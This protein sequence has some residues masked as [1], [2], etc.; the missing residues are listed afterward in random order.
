MMS[1]PDGITWTMVTHPSVDSVLTLSHGNGVWAA[2]AMSGGFLVRGVLT[3]P[4]GVTWT[5]QT[6]AGAPGGTFKASLF[7][8]GYHFTSLNLGSSNAVWRSTDGVTWT[9][10]P[11]S[12]RT[13]ANALAAGNGILV[14]LGFGSEGRCCVRSVA[15]GT[16]PAAPVVFLHNVS[17][18]S[19][20]RFYL[21]PAACSRIVLTSMSGSFGIS[22]PP[23][24]AEGQ[25][26]TI[27]ASATTVSTLYTATRDGS[28]IS[29]AA[30]SLASNASAAWAFSATG[31]RWDRIQ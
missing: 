9:A 3:S 24:P 23:S 26:F 13:P 17:T 31:N 11:V 19:S 16:K 6:I 1:S 5:L 21:A 30:S 27:T 25:V 7:S 28:T 10:L 14:G 22:F 8:D 20:S 15:G 18:G 2:T 4:D 12:S 29:S